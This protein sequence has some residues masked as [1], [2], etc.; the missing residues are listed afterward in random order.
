MIYLDLEKEIQNLDWQQENI[1]FGQMT[2]LIH[3][4]I[5]E[6]EDII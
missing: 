2:Q 6:K 4:E 5:K 3:I 1:Q